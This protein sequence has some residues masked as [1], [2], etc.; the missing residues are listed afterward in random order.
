[1][2]SKVLFFGLVL[3]ASAVH[4]EQGVSYKSDVYPMRYS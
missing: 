1:M 3:A 4:A 2:K